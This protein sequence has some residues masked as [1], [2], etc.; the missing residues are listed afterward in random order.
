MGGGEG[1][2]RRSS[3]VSIPSALTVYRECLYLGHGIKALAFCMYGRYISSHPTWFSINRELMP[4]NNKMMVR[5]S[6]L[7]NNALKSNYNY[8]FTFTGAMKTQVPHF[9]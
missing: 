6:K 7:H 8:F 4:V 2:H 9:V 5:T 1:P 3:E